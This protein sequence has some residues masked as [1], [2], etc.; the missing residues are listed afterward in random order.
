[1]VN[2]LV[3]RNDKLGDFMLAWPALSLLK[4][5]YPDSRIIVLVP[6]YTRPLAELCPWIDDVIIDQS[7][8][9]TL[10]DAFALSRRLRDVN[11]DVSISLYSETRT[12]LA[13]WL[14]GIRQRFGPA[15]KIAQL[16]LNRRLRQKRSQSARPEFEYNADLVRFYIEAQHEHAA[17]LPGPPYLKFDSN[18]LINDRN[19]FCR[20]HTIDPE[21]KLVLVHP[22]TGGSAINL[23]LDQFA[24]MIK[25]LAETNHLHFV[26][27]AGPG[28]LDTAIALSDRL[29]GIDHSVYH[30]TQGLVAF[31]RFIATGDLFISGSTG[32]LH[33]AGALDVPTVAFYSARRSATALRWQT[34]NSENRR[35]AFSPGSYQDE[36]D[37]RRMDVT[38]C[39]DEIARHYF[40]TTI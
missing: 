13:L 35:L 16:F 5:S 23:S 21:S 38:R 40:G 17:A 29:Q 8:P 28:E 32:P 19:E 37:M 34:L 7:G 31:S 33:I 36:S 24:E 3:I 11:I 27:T 18:T 26:I 22:G 39:A 9:S 25:R 2:I 1:M 14:A 20:Q 12:A 6:A 30:S 4:T 10:K 15:T